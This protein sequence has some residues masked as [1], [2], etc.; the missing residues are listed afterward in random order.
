MKNC[1]AMLAAAV[2][3]ATLIGFSVGALMALVVWILPVNRDSYEDY[4]LPEN[5]QPK[6]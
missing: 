2:L 3:L 6:K 4:K 1:I 5:W